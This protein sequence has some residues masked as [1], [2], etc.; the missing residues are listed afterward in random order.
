M[1]KKIDNS[2]FNFK[3]KQ[4]NAGSA[5][6]PITSIRKYCFLQSKYKMIAYWHD[7]ISIS[8]GFF[9]GRVFVYFLSFLHL[10]C[11]RFHFA[12]EYWL[13]LSSF[14]WVY[15]FIFQFIQRGIKQEKQVN[16]LSTFNTDI[17]FQKLSYGKGCCSL[18]SKL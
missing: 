18:L 10:A 7:I 12:T 6:P 5:I 15:Q 1:R 8:E 3:E 17:I 4:F 11:I 14:R 13:V 16:R 2:H 9:F